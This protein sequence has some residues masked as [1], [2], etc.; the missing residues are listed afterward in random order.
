ME[1]EQFFRLLDSLG[2]LKDVCF[3]RSP[4]I[5]LGKGKGFRYWVMM[6]CIQ[7]CEG[8]T[9]RAGWELESFDLSLSAPDSRYWTLEKDLWEASQ[10]F[11]LWLGEYQEQKKTKKKA[12]TRK[13]SRRRSP[14]SPKDVM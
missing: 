13:K 5:V 11:Q 4:Q 12:T 3:V 9:G 14:V 6:E 7:T 1:K 2:R 10:K 8:V